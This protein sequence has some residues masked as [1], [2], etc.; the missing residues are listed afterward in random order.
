MALEGEVNAISEGLMWARKR[1]CLGPDGACEY[2]RVSRAW[3]WPH[4]QAGPCDEDGTPLLEITKEFLLGRESN[5]PKN[6]WIG[7]EPVETE[8]PPTLPAVWERRAERFLREFEPM[9]SR[10][11]KDD[12]ERAL[13][14]MVDGGFQ[15]ELAVKIAEA[16]G[17]DPDEELPEEEEPPDD[18]KPV[19]V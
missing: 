2:H 8:R 19:R 14:E 6:L 13:D 18:N 5:C 17:I 10:L 4:C 12:L 7:L 16:K 1:K 3:R 9:V 15:L 11:S